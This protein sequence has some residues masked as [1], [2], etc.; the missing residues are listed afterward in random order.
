VAS[1]NAGTGSCPSITTFTFQPTTTSGDGSVFTLQPAQHYTSPTSF[2]GTTNPAYLVNT[3]FGTSNIYRVWRVRNVAG[4]SPTLQGPVNVF[5]GF[6]YGL[7][8]DAP[9]TGS[10]VPLETGDNRLT[11]AAGLA[12]AVWGVHG[13]LCN[14]GGGPN[15]SCVRAVRILVGQSGGAFTASI[16]Q[17]RTI[18]TTNEFYWWPGVAVNSEEQTAVPFQYVSPTRTAGRL[19]SW[20]TTKD[21]TSSN[22]EPI[23]SLATGTCAETL[24]NPDRTGDYVGAQTDPSDFH[25]FWLAGERATSVGGSCQWQTRI[26]KV[27]PSSAITTLSP[28]SEEPQTSEGPTGENATGE[29]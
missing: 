22:F 20:W 16:D 28:L 7:Q 14:I 10:A 23:S 9:Q 25:S 6:N 18:G 27:V 15:E 3:V 4:G 8:P 26:I 19:S 2:S 12:D 1:N 29:P 17:Q 5:G 24:T 11:Q 13:T 21:L